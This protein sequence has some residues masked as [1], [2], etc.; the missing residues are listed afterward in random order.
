MYK[1]PVCGM[2][3]DANTAFRLEQDGQS[4]FFCSQNCKNKFLA[5]KEQAREARRKDTNT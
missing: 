1:D 5:K 2:D 4:F 3:V